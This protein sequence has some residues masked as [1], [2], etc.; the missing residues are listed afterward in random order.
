VQYG[1]GNCLPDLE[2]RDMIPTIQPALTKEYTTRGIT[3]F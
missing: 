2:R 1:I 3:R